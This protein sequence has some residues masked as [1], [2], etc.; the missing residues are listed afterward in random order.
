MCYVFLGETAAYRRRLS[1]VGRIEE[2]YASSVL[3]TPTYRRYVR[4]GFTSCGVYTAAAAAEFEGKPR[5]R[6]CARCRF[7]G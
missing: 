6:K 4:K 2:D 7:D 3:R 1:H 5:V